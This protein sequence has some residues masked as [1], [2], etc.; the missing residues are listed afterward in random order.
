[1]RHRGKAEQET[2]ISWDEAE[3]VVHIASH[4]PAVWRRLAKL[5]IEPVR[6]WCYRDGVE[7]TRFYELPLTRFRWGLKSRHKG[8]PA[9]ANRA[10]AGVSESKPDSTHTE[11]APEPGLPVSGAGGARA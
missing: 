10:L 3:R 1:M 5:G 6:N 9:F 11:V 8:N 7:S 4:S 2:I